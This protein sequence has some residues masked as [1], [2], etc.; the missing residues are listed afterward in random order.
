MPVIDAS[1]PLQKAIVAALK[2]DAAVTALV[3]TRIY[4]ARADECHHALCFVWRVSNVSR[5]G[6]LLGRR[7]TTIQLDGWALGPST[8]ECKQLGAAIA[9]ALD[10]K[11]L[12]LD[13]PNVLVELAHD[14]TLYAREPDGITAHAIVTVTAHTEPRD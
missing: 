9:A 10:E 12:T 11:N 6:R 7:S 4:D 3:G 1:L 14:D 5:A 8:V 13:A 2:A